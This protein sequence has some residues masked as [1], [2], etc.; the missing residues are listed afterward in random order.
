ML[1]SELISLM[2]ENLELD[3]GALKEDSTFDEIENWDSLAVIT[4]LAI[5]HENTGVVIPA[6]IFKQFKTVKDLIDY[7]HSTA[8]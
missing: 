5:I 2:E 3:A 1:R 8:Y 4:T 7:I 6:K